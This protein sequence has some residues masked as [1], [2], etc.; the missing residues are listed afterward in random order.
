MRVP[1][2]STSPRRGRSRP[3]TVRSTVDL[4]APLGPTM[5]ATDSVG[6]LD[7]DTLQHVAAAVAGHHS[8]EPQHHRV[9]P[10]PG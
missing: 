4:P 9:L 10:L 8:A 3:L 2:S 7:V 1:S 6:H 5:Q